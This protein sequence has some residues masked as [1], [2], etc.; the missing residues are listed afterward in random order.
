MYGI[1]SCGFV[2]GTACPKA[3]LYK[4]CLD[5]V[6]KEMDG[7]RLVGGWLVCGCFWYGGCWFL[8]CGCGL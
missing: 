8:L 1:V 7:L 3:F 2:G 4:N 6:K 5:W